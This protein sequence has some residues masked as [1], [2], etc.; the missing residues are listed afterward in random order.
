[1][2]PKRLFFILQ[3]NH[4][5]QKNSKNRILKDS[6]R[7]EPVVPCAERPVQPHLQQ[8]LRERLQPVPVQSEGLH[9][10][11]MVRGDAQGGERRVV[12]LWHILN[13]NFKKD[14]FTCGRYGYFVIAEVYFS[15]VLRRRRKTIQI[16]I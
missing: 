9:L 12:Q 2:F 4:M 14:F 13:L 3:Y 5:P 6:H 16:R 10:A 15:G 11:I 1:M 8:L 7:F